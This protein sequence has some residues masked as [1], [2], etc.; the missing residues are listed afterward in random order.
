MNFIYLGAVSLRSRLFIFGG[1]GPT[2][3]GDFWQYTPGARQWKHIQSGR[4][5][6]E[7]GSDGTGGGGG[8]GVGVVPQNVLWPAARYGHIATTFGGDSILI[9]GG[10]GDGHTFRDD[11]WKFYIGKLHPFPSP[12]FSI[13]T[14][15]STPLRLGYTTRKRLGGKCSCFTR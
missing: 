11:L 8:S 13:L 3:L 2:A 6:T 1:Q 9:F 5:H 7:R 14:I 15:L 10:L 12:N 4:E